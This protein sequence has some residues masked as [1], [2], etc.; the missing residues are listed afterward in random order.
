MILSFPNMGSSV[1]A[2]KTLFEQLDI[3]VVLAD[4][5]N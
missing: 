5:T 1:I 2:F 3:K 4:P